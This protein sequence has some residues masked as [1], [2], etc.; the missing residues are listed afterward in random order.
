MNQAELNK[1]IHQARRDYDGS[2]LVNIEA[3]VIAALVGLGLHSWLAAIA[4]GVGLLAALRVPY[5]GQG[6]AVTLSLLWGVAGWQ[7]A[8]IFHLGTP[9]HVVFAV[10]AALMGLGAHKGYRNY[11]G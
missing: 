6:L 10:V 7:A 2:K 9:A 11:W 8:S 1:A 4:V 3:L 5:L